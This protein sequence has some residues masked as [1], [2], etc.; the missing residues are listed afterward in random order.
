MV[1]DLKGFTK[2]LELRKL[3]LQ[4]NKTKILEKLIMFTIYQNYT[5]AL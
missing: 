4:I 5:L 1:S 3:Y 2:F